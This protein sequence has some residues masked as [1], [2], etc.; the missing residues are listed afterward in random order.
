MAESGHIQ[1][2]DLFRNLTDDDR[3]ALLGVSGESAHFSEEEIFSEGDDG[4]SL[5]IVESGR[6]SLQRWIVEGD[7]RRTLL[8]AGPGEVFGEMSFMD[9]QGRSAACIAEEE[10]VLRC[11]DR[12][13]FDGWAED[14]PN[15]AMHV[16]SNLVCIVTD[17][18]RRTNDLYRAALHNELHISGAHLL[19][20]QHLIEQSLDVRILLTSGSTVNGTILQIDK[21]A[22]GHEII[23]RDESERIVMVPYHAVVTVAFDA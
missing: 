1:S 5:F 16:L 9:R 14:H 21:S 8:V 2:S 4:E 22:A 7:I 6:V 17:R 23:L 10:T 3:D 12:T 19:N 18:L 20:F 11:L 15:A 13:T